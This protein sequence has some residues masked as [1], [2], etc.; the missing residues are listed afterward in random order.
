M[1]ID[2][3]K[4]IGST[5][6][7]QL[8]TVIDDLQTEV[9]S[10][11]ITQARIEATLG[12]RSE[13]QFE[14]KGELWYCFETRCDRCLTPINACRTIELQTEVD[15]EEDQ[16]FIKGNE[17]DVGCLVS[18]EIISDYPV[19][20]I[21]SNECKGLCPDCGI[22]LNQESCSC[23]EGHIDIRMAQFKDL[24]DSEFKEV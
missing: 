10:A 19:K 20:N 24:L 16:A 3:N 2:I 13:H 22:N 7:Y 11:K 15:I 18:L 23:H 17:L 1:I 5:K 4:I 6:P 12:R 21:C 14:V 9:I 8:E